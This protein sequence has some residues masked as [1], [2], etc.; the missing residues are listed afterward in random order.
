MPNVMAL[1]IVLELGIQQVEL[2]TAL[3]LTMPLK[4][5]P[6]RQT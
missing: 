5:I 3:W 2:A 1:P 6:S 4:V